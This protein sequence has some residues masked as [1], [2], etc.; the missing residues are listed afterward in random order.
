M[1][2]SSG[3]KIQSA[4]QLYAVLHY[5]F[6]TQ[7]QTCNSPVVTI[8]FAPD[9]EINLGALDSRAFPIRVA[10]N[11]I[12][13]GDFEIG[14]IVNKRSTGTR[15]FFPYLYKLGYAN[16]VDIAHVELDCGDSYAAAFRMYDQSEI[17]KICLYGPRTDTKDWRWGISG[18]KFKNL[19]TNT[20]WPIREGINMG[21]MVMGNK[22]KISY[23][24]I[25]GFGY[26]GVH[27]ADMVRTQDLG[28]VTPLLCFNENTDVQGSFDFHHNYVHNCK[29]FGFGYGLYL[30]AGSGPYKITPRFSEAF[31]TD[32]VNIIYDYF[33]N[34][35]RPEEQANVHNNIFF[36]NKHDI[37]S[38]GNRLSMNIRQNTFS[39]RSADFNINVHN[40]EAWVCNPMGTIYN[41]GQLVN[42]NVFKGVG[43]SFTQIED[44][45]FYRGGSM[46]LMYPNINEIATPGSPNYVYNDAR[47]EIN[48]NYFKTPQVGVNANGTN[49]HWPTGGGPFQRD[50]YN[51]IRIGQ[52]YYHYSYLFDGPGADDHIQ[53]GE[54]TGSSF[55]NG[56]ICHEIPLPLNSKTPISIIAS[57][58]SADHFNGVPA[59]SAPKTITEGETLCFDTHLCEDKNRNNPPV[60][61]VLN[62]WRFHNEKSDLA[63]EVRTDNTNV[64]T[65]VSY[66]FD[67]IG[68]NNVTLFTIDQTLANQNEWRASDI[69]HQ[70]ITI[71]PRDKARYLTFWIKDTYVG[72]ELSVLTPW[73]QSPATPNDWVDDGQLPPPAQS[74]TGFEKFVKINGQLMW[75]DDIE[76]DEGWQY[77]KILLNHGQP[78]APYNAGDLEIGIRSVNDVDAERVRGVAVYIDDVYINCDDGSNALRDGELEQVVYNTNPHLLTTLHSPWWAEFDEADNPALHPPLAGTPCPPAPF[79]TAGWNPFDD[80]LLFPDEVRSGSFAYRLFVKSIEF[81]HNLSNPYYKAPHVFKSVSQPYNVNSCLQ[82]RLAVQDNFTVYPSPSVSQ[83][84]ISID[85]EGSPQ[86]TQYIEVLSMH[87][88]VVYSSN[89]TGNHFEFKNNLQPGIYIVRLTSKQGSSEK[90]LVITKS[91]M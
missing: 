70:L 58:T 69:T 63:D 27:V 24:E 66:R 74:N 82:Q 16:D 28:Y 15:I 57:N 62:F 72:R 41:N 88:S 91:G 53:I 43:C 18:D 36:E 6:V 21:I 65:P 84:K 64:V 42:E 78:G 20:S 75:R 4:E 2:Y 11:I 61:N 13:R 5:Y 54:G 34:F 79:P 19:C 3:N 44:N 17:E 35:V 71:K 56:N 23:C 51:F 60:N 30:S 49:L 9:I 40:C 86:T 46:E 33:L 47:I 25:Y 90:K 68:I 80:Q 59:T 12:I 85:H 10:N 52:D 39:Q 7:P 87:C 83:N 14:S 77:V 81:R 26:S 55:Q 45:I 22:C 89:F 37:G 38:S 67:K 8:E 50:G 73:P 32:E 48:G 29:S 31:C 1:P 76:G